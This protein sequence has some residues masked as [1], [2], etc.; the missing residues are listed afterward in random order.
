LLRHVIL[1]DGTTA[2]VRIDGGRI[3]AVTGVDQSP[4]SPPSPAVDL[5][6]YLLV[7]SL[8]EPHAHLDKAF[9]ADNVINLDGSLL[10]AIEAWLPART[11][12]QVSDIATRAWAVTLRYL[13]HGT[14]AIRAHIDTGEGIG[15]RAIE[16]L[17]AVRRAIGDAIDLQIVAMCGRPT[18]GVA[19][20]ANR[21]F[22][23]EALAAG[24]DLVGGAPAIDDHPMA[25]VDV[26]AGAAADAGVGLDLHIDETLDPTVRTIDRLVEVARAGFEGPI[27]ASHAVSLSVQPPDRLRAIAEALADAG[28][29]VVTLPQTNLF[30]QGREHG[31]RAPR[32]LTAVRQLLDA[33]VT[34]AAGGDNLQDPF[35]LMGR[36]DPLETASLLVVAGHVMP[37]EAFAAVTAVGRQLLGFP[38][39]SIEAGA[40]AD[41]LAI[42]AT[43]VRGAM[44]SAT[45]DR[46]V[47]RNGRIL[48]RTRVETETPWTAEPVWGEEG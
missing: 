36:A 1:A 18:T 37:A 15:L 13:A 10:G 20:A 5:D 30:L 46:V 38:A 16:A 21:A 7:P 48:S 26:L 28:V 25:A 41:L 35:N 42:R 29:G 24:A 23:A 6:G 34:V 14:T 17:L 8:V 40:P 12:F 44:A 19:G 3:A 31:C 45:P 47:I 4:A 33:G 39:V 22:L 32:G 2:D 9:T 27:A 43:T 11:T